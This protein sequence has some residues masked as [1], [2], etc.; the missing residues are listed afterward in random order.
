MFGRLLRII[1]KVLDLIPS[2]K[3]RKVKVLD[4]RG[5]LTKKKE[6]DWRDDPHNPKKF[7]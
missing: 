7:N 5:S 2:K 1:E 4:A 6:A 3:R